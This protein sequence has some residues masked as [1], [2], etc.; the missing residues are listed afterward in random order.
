M[1]RFNNFNNNNIK[2]FDLSDEEMDETIAQYYGSEVINGKK[3][4]IC[5]YN[6][7]EQTEVIQK[8]NNCFI[9]FFSIF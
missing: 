8:L 1:N 3:W 5:K 9:F 6:D 7:C 4:F 2:D